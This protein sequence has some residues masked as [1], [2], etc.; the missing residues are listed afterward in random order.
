MNL[1][2]F[3]NEAPRVETRTPTEDTPEKKKARVGDIGK[4]ERLQQLD[5]DKKG[6][7]VRPV[8]GVQGGVRLKKRNVKS[9][10]QYV[11]RV[12]DETGEK[13]QAPEK[14]ELKYTAGASK[15][16]KGA[17]KEI[18]LA[19]KVNRDK[20]TAADRNLDAKIQDDESGRLRDSVPVQGIDAPIE[21]RPY[22]RH[23]YQPSGVGM[24]KTLDSD[25]INYMIDATK[26]VNPVKKKQS[27]VDLIDRGGIENTKMRE[28]TARDLEQL[29][30]EAEKLGS[31]D[32]AYLT[33]EVMKTQKELRKALETQDAEAVQKIAFQHDVS[34]EVIDE[35]IGKFGKA[36]DTK[37]GEGK[38]KLL[39]RLEGNG[40]TA[41]M[42]SR[43]GGDLGKDADEFRNEDGTY[44]FARMQ[45]ASPELYAKANYNRSRE[46]VRTYLKQGGKDAYASHEGIRS[47]ADM[48]LEHIRSLKAAGREGGLDDPSNWVWASGELNRL[49]GERDLTGDESSVSKYAQGPKETDRSQQGPSFDEFVG[50]DPEKLKQVKKELGGSMKNGRGQG[51]FAAGKY[52]SLSKAQVTELRSKAKKL[53]F[54]PE[55]VKG[56]F[57]DA[58]PRRPELPSS[59]KDKYGVEVPSY[60][61]GGREAYDDAVT[62]KSRNKIRYQDLVTSLKAIHKGMNEKDVLATQE[63][64]KGIKDII[65][66]PMVSRQAK[67]ETEKS[68]LDDF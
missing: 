3:L 68:Q 60:L 20:I 39:A 37:K 50:E 38:Y 43:Y 46:M 51:V 28:P 64:Q 67:K 40:A 21:D 15:D 52:D 66:Q 56:L 45:E 65:S 42:T 35:F 49:R 32:R 5:K 58:A 9:P 12:A 62:A 23:A 54:N 47:V 11:D 24:N 22:Y 29:D 44:N 36:R 31:K 19:R 16:E 27:D 8:P 34:D 13:R 18:K 6:P 14:D 61:G 17:P 53:G 63:G 57:P 1:K 2:Q 10:G 30:P 26:D 48:D 41:P 33:P 25:D 55:Q 7:A 59:S 4:V